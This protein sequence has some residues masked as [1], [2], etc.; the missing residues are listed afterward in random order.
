M[1]GP[2]YPGVAC[3]IVSSLQL[4]L[5][6]PVKFIDIFNARARN[7]CAKK[8]KSCGKEKIVFYYQ[9]NFSWHIRKRFSECANDFKG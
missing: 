1:D 7:S 5:N 6:A 2:F 3:A 4:A 8:K 9:G